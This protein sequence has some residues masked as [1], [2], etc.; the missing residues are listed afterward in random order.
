MEFTVTEEK[1][2]I[3]TLL[4]EMIIKEFVLDN[5][6]DDINKVPQLIYLELVNYLAFNI[7]FENIVINGNKL[8]GKITYG[9]PNISGALL[10]NEYIV[11]DFSVSVKLR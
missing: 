5:T 10:N 7:L 11:L 4:L 8:S 6:F 1:K 2:S 3:K 9:K